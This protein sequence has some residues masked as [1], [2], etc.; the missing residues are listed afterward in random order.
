VA[1]NRHWAED[2]IQRDT[3]P[4]TTREI[5]ISFFG[6]PSDAVPC[7]FGPFALGRSGPIPLPPR[8][9]GDQK[10]LTAFRRSGL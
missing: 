8:C 6:Q 1:L 3:E 7:Q 4:R 9:H 2:V 5:Q 10:G